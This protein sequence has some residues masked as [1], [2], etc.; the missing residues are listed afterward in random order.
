MNA[1]DVQ[2]LRCRRCGGVDTARSIETILGSCE[3]VGLDHDGQP[4]YCGGTTV[5]WDSST[6]TGFDCRSCLAEAPE[7]D[8]LFAVLTDP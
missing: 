8:Q 1:G 4:D 6:T 5:H 7:L 2:Q 3:I